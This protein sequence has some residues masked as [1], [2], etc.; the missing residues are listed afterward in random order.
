MILNISKVIV[1]KSS[2]TYLLRKQDQGARESLLSQMASMSSAQIVSAS[3][4]QNKGIPP[5]PLTYGSQ[6]TTGVVG[7]MYRPGCLPDPLTNPLIYISMYLCKYTNMYN[8]FRFLAP[9]CACVTSIVKLMISDC[10]CL[11]ELKRL[12]HHDPISF[13]N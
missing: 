2:K 12:C 11:A 10:Y 5:G 4:V 6:V 9:K 7:S 1:T 3:A 8:I 13:L